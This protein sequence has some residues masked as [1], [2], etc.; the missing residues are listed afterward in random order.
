MPWSNFPKR[1]VSGVSPAQA[2][3]RYKAVFES[4]FLSPSPSSSVG[5]ADYWAYFSKVFKIKGTTCPLTICLPKRPHSKL[6]LSLSLLPFIVLQ[7]AS[8]LK[9]RQLLETRSMK[10]VTSPFRT[11]YRYHRNI[12]EDFAGRYRRCKQEGNKLSSS[13]RYYFFL[14]SFDISLIEY[15][16]HTIF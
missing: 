3:S 2:I 13:A 14:P 5:V 4:C 12:F 9:K 10:G 7:R 1:R 6:S 15:F 8:S 16:V 11:K